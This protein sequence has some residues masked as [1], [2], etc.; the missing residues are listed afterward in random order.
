MPFLHSSPR[1]HL[2]VAAL[3][4][5]LLAPPLA[6]SDLIRINGAGASFPAPLYMRWFR[7]YY[8]A[9]PN[10]L[11]DYQAIGSGA[12]VANLIQGRFDFAGSDEPLTET[13]LE[14][15]GAD[16]IQIPM[17]AGAIVMAYHLPGIEELKLSREA[18]S[19]I[20]LGE[21][22]RWNDPVI[23]AA[24]PGVALP[25]RPIVVVTRVDSSGTSL[26]VTRHLSAISE[27]F[28]NL[29]GSNLK[30]VWPK[31]LQDR[32]G[33]IRGSGNGGVARL[34]QAVPGAVG[35]VQFAYAHLSGISM[36]TLQNEAGAFVP[37]NEASFQA[38]LASFRAELD[39]SDLAD[40]KGA[41][42]YPILAL[43]WLIVP[44]STEEPKSR[45]LREVLRYA[46]TDGQKDAAPLGYIPLSPAAVEQ[47]MER[48]DLRGPIPS[49]S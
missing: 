39:L 49:D 48:L 45:T 29:V 31:A 14:Q 23:A 12:G 40:P 8:Q 35:Y 24:N 7:D 19:A 36:A 16:W 18:L 28:A 20:F 25:D 5:A 42:S 44:R 3:I 4:L 30:P 13:A 21:A 41:E 1:W 17:A 2:A 33:L 22:V 26:I 9:H 46:L 34:V 10:V 37:P 6:A 11:V 43:S 38:T 32:G 47:I 15:L 27:T